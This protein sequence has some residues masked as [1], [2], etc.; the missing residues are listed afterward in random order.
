MLVFRQDLSLKFLGVVSVKTLG[1]TSLFENSVQAL[2]GD[3]IELHLFRWFNRNV[4]VLHPSLFG[5]LCLLSQ[6]HLLRVFL[7]SL[8]W[9]VLGSLLLGDV[10]L[11]PQMV[12]FLVVII[13][14]C[15]GLVH[16]SYARF[17]TWMQLISLNITSVTAFDSI[18]IILVVLLLKLVQSFTHLLNSLF[19]FIDDLL[20]VISVTGNS[21]GKLRPRVRYFRS[22]CFDFTQHIFYAWVNRVVNRGLFARKFADFIGCL[23]DGGGF[24][25]EWPESSL[26]HARIGSWGPRF[27]DG[28]LRIV[29]GLL[30]PFLGS[31]ILL[32]N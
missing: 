18:R 3:A 24:I 7:R 23:R 6:L 28:I 15:S 29:S 21:L 4:K 22:G 10:R 17:L 16:D 27:N 2:L 11:S 19:I 8:P 5:V 30:V 1:E 13:D 26:L 14:G 9:I 32:A 20:I 12:T 25:F 31:S